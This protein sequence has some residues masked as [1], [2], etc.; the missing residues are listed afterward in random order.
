MKKF[1]E[2]CRASF[3]SHK[4]DTFGLLQNEAH[5]RKPETD[6]RSLTLKLEF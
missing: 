6:A 1:L 5:E 2:L 4:N 3:I